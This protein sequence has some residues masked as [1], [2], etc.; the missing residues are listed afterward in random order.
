MS[1]LQAARSVLRLLR[2]A[3]RRK[4]RG[5]ASWA[6]IA[7]ATGDGQYLAL[8]IDCF[9]TLVARLEPDWEQRAIARQIGELVGMSAHRAQA[10]LRQAHRVACGVAP[11]SEDEPAAADIWLAFSR[12]AGLPDSLCA[13]LVRTELDL[14]AGSA[15]LEPQ[16]ARIVELA[17]SSKIPFVVTSDTRWSA[18]QISALL[19]RLGLSL[20]P[21]TIVC[22][23]DHDKSK[24][25]GGLYAVAMNRLTGTTSRDLLPRNVLHVGND[26]LADGYSAAA[27][28]F[29]YSIVPRSLLDTSAAQK[30][31]ATKLGFGT[32]GP[33]FSVFCSR[34]REELPAHRLDS[35]AFVA[36]DG[37]FLMRC[38]DTW[39]RQLS[40]ASATPAYLRISRISAR[41]AAIHDARSIRDLAQDIHSVRAGAAASREVCAFL[42]LSQ[43]HDAMFGAG[44]VSVGEAIDRLAGTH[45]SLVLACAARMRTELASY[46]GTSIRGAC[47]DIGWKGTT[48]ALLDRAVPQQ[49]RSRWLYF[50]RWSGSGAPSW[51][52][53][54]IGLVEDQTVDGRFACS[55]PWE[56]YALLEAIAQEDV[57][58][59]PAGSVFDDG[60]SAGDPRA[61][62][63]AALVPPDAI[64]ATRDGILKAVAL[65]AR[66]VAESGHPIA[67]Q[68]ARCARLR[69]FRL[70]FFPDRYTASWA[71]SVEVSEA[72]NR[73]WR[74][75]LGGPP[76]VHPLL[77]P[78][79]WLNGFQA[80]WKGLWAYRS[81]G[82]AGCIF[83]LGCSW[84]LHAV[85]GR[86]APLVEA[87][88]SFDRG[89]DRN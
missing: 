12:L 65:A 42:G 46:L 36:R 70:A 16:A 68:Y 50:A 45:S 9:D 63:E 88:R 73:Q 24:F 49:A 62:A 17:L 83:W 51:R 23:S 86:G 76:A 85:K 43:F 21:N 57:M 81:A 30:A 47:V 20:P 56:L 28:G 87:I 54:D 13:H 74:S 8:S 5:P 89:P 61:G 31:H 66:C 11:G 34:L 39:W 58:A 4:L 72:H 37:H 69:I 41:L 25:R 77:H 35:A 75:S 55:G 38:A 84:L 44:E 33:A 80:P 53:G 32:L 52:E 15:R 78:L 19:D 71:A 64:V 29:N 6:A 7:A 22:S 2:G 59:P 40:D 18:E 14:L 67:A 79:R 27:G 60:L 3:A 1:V 26:L 82:R 48:A 10:M